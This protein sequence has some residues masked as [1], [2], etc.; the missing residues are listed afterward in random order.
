MTAILEAIL[1]FFKVV[2]TLINK[3]ELMAPLATIINN[4]VMT[5]WNNVVR[6][7]FAN[8]HDGHPD[9]YELKR[10]I[11][12]AE[13]CTDLLE[14][15]INLSDTDIEGDIRCYE[16][17]ITIHEYLINAQS[18]SYETVHVGYSS[19]DASKLY[20]NKYVKS[21]SLDKK[22]KE[23]RSQLI[24]KYQNKI[25]DRKRDAFWLNYKSEYE[26][27]KKEL[28]KSTKERDK[29][30]A[31]KTGYTKIERIT[32]HMAE[33]EVILEKDRELK[34]RLEQSEKQFIANCE[35]FWEKLAADDG[36]YD[37]YLDKYPI[38]KSAPDFALKRDEIRKLGYRSEIDFPTALVGTLCTLALAVF[39]IIVGSATDISFFGF[40]GWVCAI[41]CGI[42]SIFLGKSF[43]ED[44]GDSRAAKNIYAQ[45]VREY[46]ATIDKMLAIPKYEGHVDRDKEI[47]IP[48]KL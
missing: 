10:L 39:L 44:I 11:A 16:N 31:A 17:L 41:P 36:E 5:A 12:R 42:A 4:S 35:A 30:V 32:A 34:S 1:Q 24:S 48:A 47:K 33:I 7:T 18:Y 21:K 3:D 38:L 8:D 26:F 25:R 22:A 43:I 14:Q 27:L 23:Y 46:N 37:A 2:G 28:R 6:P 29:L 9:D 45:K 13:H 40:L 20:E 19:W 15:A